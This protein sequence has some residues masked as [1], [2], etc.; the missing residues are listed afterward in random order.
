[1]KHVVL[2]AAADVDIVL[3]GPSGAAAV[4]GPQKGATVPAVAQLDAA[5]GHLALIIRRQLGVDVEKLAGGGAAGGLGAGLVALLSATLRSGADI[6]L[7]T[8]RMEQRLDGAGLVIT[9]EGKMDG[10]TLYGKAPLAVARL[11]RR[12]R[13][14][15]VAVVGGVGA[16]EQSLHCDGPDAILPAV[17]GPIELDRAM[18]GADD[19]LA[20]AAAR[21][22]RLLAV[23]A[24]LDIP[25]LAARGG[26]SRPGRSI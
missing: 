13:I 1:M 3:C 16:G 14:P 19:M 24:R 2:I 12:R 6:V 17:P 18:A 5:L 20:D 4:F 26:E 8:T 21:L 9:G 7:E 11:A 22:G 23:G 25:P 10:Q 15:V